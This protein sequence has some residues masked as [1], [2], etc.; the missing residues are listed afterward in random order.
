MDD[1]RVRSSVRAW[2]RV[3][4]TVPG[5]VMLPSCLSVSR[6]ASVAGAV[7]AMTVLGLYG[8]PNVTAASNDLSYHRGGKA[9][10]AADVTSVVMK[11]RMI[12]GGQF[13]TLALDS[14]GGAWSW[15]YNAA[16]Q[17][18]DGTT[19]QRKM[20][21]KVIGLTGKT[22]VSVAGGGGPQ[23]GAAGGHSLA[24]DSTGHVW[25][26][27]GNR[28]GELGQGTTDSSAHGT[29]VEVK[30]GLQGGTYLGDTSSIVAIAG[31]RYHD[32]AVS[33]DGKV[34]AWGDG[35]SGQLGDG[36]SGQASTPVKVSQTTMVNAVIDVA[37][38]E[39]HSLAI[40]STGRVWAWGQNADG[41]LGDG[42]NTSAST[43][44][45]VTIP[46][47]RS[48]V[49]VAGAATHSVAVMSDGTAWAWGDNSRGE[50][51]RSGGGTTN[52]LVAVQMYT[53]TGAIT[54]VIAAAAGEDHSV[55]LTGAGA[56][57]AAGHNAYG[58]VGDG[59]TRQR[60]NLV[61]AKISSGMSNAIA[62]AAGQDHS[63]A[64][65]GGNVYTF[66]FNQTSSM[67][68][69]GGGQLGDG[70]TTNRSTPVKVL[71]L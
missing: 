31:G 43:P 16:G 26:W 15:G 1:R 24:L 12:A 35:G 42:T 8:V 67:S 14:L 55:L 50:L 22:I 4:G 57:W 62:I 56:V 32:L 2:H 53:S 59:T 28:N 23:T 21:V 36:T 66:G 39:E 68:P 30:A 41:E 44:V 65:S 51:A 48:A 54:N 60:N 3:I 49:Y 5:R 18:G 58:E 46:G 45:S 9:L 33:A 40:D 37:A 38:G 7:F 11:T 63:I 64:V 61:Q 10:S 70:T 69:A 47:S 27:G 52:S 19:T 17:L 29:P 6:R 71:A 34:W 13:H 25:A 20:P